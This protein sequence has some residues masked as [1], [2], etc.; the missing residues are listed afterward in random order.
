MV[1]GSWGV[2]TLTFQGP[3]Y[4]GDGHLLSLAAFPSTKYIYKV[5]SI[6]AELTQKRPF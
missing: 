4:E 6:K 5:Y 2:S 1:V 3:A